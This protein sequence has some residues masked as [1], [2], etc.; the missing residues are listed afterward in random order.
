MRDDLDD[1]LMFGLGVGL[2][3]VGGVVIHACPFI[4]VVGRCLVYLILI[5]D[6]IT[7]PNLC[8]FVHYHDNCQHSGQALAS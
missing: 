5:S 8:L 6:E 2:G 3:R 7:R 4:C 1:L